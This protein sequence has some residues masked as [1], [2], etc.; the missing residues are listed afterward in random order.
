VVAYDEFHKLRN[1]EHT[2]EDAEQL[3]FDSAPGVQHLGGDEDGLHVLLTHV[4]HETEQ[5]H[6]HQR[7]RNDDDE[8]KLVDEQ[9]VGPRVALLLQN[10]HG[11]VLRRLTLLVFRHDAACQ[12]LEGD[13]VT[14]GE[15]AQHQEHQGHHTHRHQ[16]DLPEGRLLLGD[17]LVLARAVRDAGDVAL[18]EQVVARVATGLLLESL[19]A[20]LVHDNVC[21]NHGHHNPHDEVLNAALRVHVHVDVQQVGREFVAVHVET[22]VERDA[23]HDQQLR[24]EQG[25]LAE[26]VHPLQKHLAQDWVELFAV[27]DPGHQHGDDL[28]VWKQ[29]RQ[30]D[31]QQRQNLDSRLPHL[32]D[33]VLKTEVHQRGGQQVLLQDGAV[34]AD[35][36]PHLGLCKDEHSHVQ[37][38]PH[39]H[40]LPDRLGD[41]FILHQCWFVIRLAE[42]VPGRQ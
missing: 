26:N 31:H 12:P 35:L 33:A 32:H 21:R 37:N 11:R 38:Q 42:V 6:Q 20:V 23:H 1:L 39:G 24:V 5:Q 14:F 27:A 4:D 2:R 8:H 25:L 36:R 19:L 15:H 3:D 30:H 40:A 7:Q 9:H 18:V 41:H 17:L 13:R 29:P 16:C 10:E 34:E 28:H 22:L